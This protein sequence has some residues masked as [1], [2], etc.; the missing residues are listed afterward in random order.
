M[1]F[2]PDEKWK[3]IEMLAWHEDDICQV[4]DRAQTVLE[5]SAAQLC[6]QYR[7]QLNSAAGSHEHWSPRQP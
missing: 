2:V 3:T 5:K 7:V 1:E 6:L 4:L